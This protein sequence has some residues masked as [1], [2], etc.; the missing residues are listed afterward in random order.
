MLGVLDGVAGDL[1]SKLLKS[2]ADMSPRI[3]HRNILKAVEIGGASECGAF[4]STKT[5]THLFRGKTL[6]PSPPPVR[7]ARSKGHCTN[8]AELPEF[9]GTR[10]K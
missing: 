7:L 5:N 2:T 8:I 10:S 9:L 3:D 1:G 4:P 6:G